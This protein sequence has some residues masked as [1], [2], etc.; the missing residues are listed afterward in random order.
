ME[1]SKHRI[2]IGTTDSSI[3]VFEFDLDKFYRT[4]GTIESAEYMFKFLKEAFGLHLSER[5][6]EHLDQYRSCEQLSDIY[7]NCM[8]A[9]ADRDYVWIREQRDGVE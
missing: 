5:I 6:L 8:A 4:F 9:M 7:E 3:D 1:K 2:T